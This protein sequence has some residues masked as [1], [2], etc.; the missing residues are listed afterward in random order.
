MKKILTMALIAAMLCS[1]VA[2]AEKEDAEAV[3]AAE[4]VTESAETHVA[5]NDE[6]YTLPEEETE[7]EVSESA[8][9]CAEDT[10]EPTVIGGADAETEI[11]IQ[12]A[13]IVTVNVTMTPKMKVVDSV[14]VIELRDKD[15]KVIGTKEEWIGGITEALE[16][17]F[18]VPELK[19][20]DTY[21][22]RLKSGLNYIKY[23]DKTYGVG[24]DVE[25]V[26]YGYRN[27]ND[28]PCVASEFALEGCP[29]YEHAIVTYVEGVQLQLY[30]DARLIDS[31]AM[32]PVRPVAEALGLD[33]RY[34][35]AYNSIVCEIA[36]KQAI[37]NVGTAYATIMGADMYMPANCEIIDNTA[38]VPAR[39]LAEAFGCTVEALE[40]GD[41]IDVCIGESSV[42]K[43][44]RMSIPVNRWGI[45]S[46][47]NYMVWI[48][49]SDFKVR[50]Y[51]GSKGKWEEVK[52]FTCA[53]GAPGSP[54][55]TGSFEYEYRMPQWSY[56]GYYV[57][58]CL[59]FYGNYAM[60]STLLQYNGTPY[61]NRVGV[62]ISHGCVRLRKAD[63][64][65][66]DRNLPVK[67]RV[68]I[69]E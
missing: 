9:E 22:L 16:L 56:P 54:T 55:I 52:S 11:V 14:A 5:E 34:D 25:L 38:F 49:K 36:G 41:H 26:A 64:D 65:W 27:E 31:T 67:S 10:T 8:V 66:L 50:V 30:P 32:V 24:E 48:D 42:V 39:V 51:K 29:L 1:Q 60:H 57:G 7:E 46:R 45:S 47:T 59:V 33:V 2:F 12:D 62:M 68:Y 37:F 3:T 20:G 18:D 69:T 58:P 6:E 43:E 63:I 61:D 19:A 13:Q 35:E 21:K 53:I 17:K 15:G 4:G 40:F 23:Y 28:E 44:Y